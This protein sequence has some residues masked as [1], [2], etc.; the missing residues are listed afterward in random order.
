MYW[1]VG[2]ASLVIS[3]GVSLPVDEEALLLEQLPL[4][5]MATVT[6]TVTVTDVVGNWHESDS[7]H[8]LAVLCAMALLTFVIAAVLA[9]ALPLLVSSE[10]NQIVRQLPAAI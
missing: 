1:L 4:N 5:P 6:V 10:L 2:R 3:R 8:P 7:N 9:F